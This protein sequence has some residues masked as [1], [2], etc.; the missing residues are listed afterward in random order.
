MNNNPERSEILPEWLG[1]IHQL[2]RVYHGYMWA[3]SKKDDV[4]PLSNA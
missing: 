3:G 4:D 1:Q 2:R